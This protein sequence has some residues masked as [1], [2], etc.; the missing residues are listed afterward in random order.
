VA[1]V[2]VHLEVNVSNLSNEP[3]S[4]LVQLFLSQNRVDQKSIDLKAEEV[5]KVAFQFSHDKPG[6]LNAEVRLSGDSLPADDLYYFPLKVKG[7][8]RFS[9]SMAIPRCLSK[10][11]RAT[12]CEGIESGDPGE[13]GLCHPGD[14]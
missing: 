7:K 9:L 13:V 14:H 4:T 6:W 8:T 3:K 1:G 5:G 10:Q 12:T 11:V 2:P